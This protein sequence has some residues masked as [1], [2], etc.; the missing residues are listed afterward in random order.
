MVILFCKG[1]ERRG[2]AGVESGRK[3]RRKADMER[4]P[5]EPNGM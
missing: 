1:E 3:E 5:K 4:T 2:A